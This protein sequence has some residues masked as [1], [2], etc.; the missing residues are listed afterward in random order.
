MSLLLSSLNVDLIRFLISFLAYTPDTARLSRCCKALNQVDRLYE[1]SGH[2]KPHGMV[3]IKRKK[4]ESITTTDWSDGKK[5]GNKVSYV[6]VTRE[7]KYVLNSI[8]SYTHGKLTR[9]IWYNWDGEIFGIHDIEDGWRYFP[10]Q[11]DGGPMIM[12]IYA[13]QYRF[14]FRE[15][16][17]EVNLL[18]SSRD[19]G[20]DCVIGRTWHFNYEGELQKTV[21]ARSD[22]YNLIEEYNKDPATGELMKVVIDTRQSKRKQDESRKHPRRVN[23]RQK[24]QIPDIFELTNYSIPTQPTIQLEDETSDSD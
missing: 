7:H 18:Q 10:G 20:L 5:H 22:E 16:G 14:G 1:F 13:N 8:E 17:I 2:K 15:S 3:K 9:E 19:G 23:K 21:H 12:I 24:S 11:P 4:W 6:F